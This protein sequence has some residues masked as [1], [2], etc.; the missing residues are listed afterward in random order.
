MQ[1]RVAQDVRRMPFID[2]VVYGK[3]EKEAIPY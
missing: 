3:L 2:K 1:R